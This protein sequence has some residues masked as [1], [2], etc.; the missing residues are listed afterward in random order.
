MDSSDNAG[1][2]RGGAFGSATFPPSLNMRRQAM[3][4]L[5]AAAVAPAPSKIFFARFVE[6]FQASSRLQL[7]PKTCS[8]NKVDGPPGIDITQRKSLYVNS[9][10]SNSA[11]NSSTSTTSP[12]VRHTSSKAIFPVLFASNRSKRPLSCWSSKLACAE[13]Q[14][15]KNAE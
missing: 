12:N 6:T 14:A 4:S 8:N 7:V 10:W 15:A 9:P 3:F 2:A 11:R 13:M 5:L 1:E